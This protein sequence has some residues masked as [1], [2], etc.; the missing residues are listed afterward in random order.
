[1]LH[2]TGKTGGWRRRAAGMM[3]AHSAL[4]IIVAAAIML[5]MTTMVMYYAAKNIIH[6][7]TEMY[8]QRDLNAI[9]QSI[10]G[11]M[12]RVEEAVDNTAWV[13]ERNLTKP[14][15]MF[16]L[17]RCLLNNNDEIL[18]SSITFV[19]DYFPEK[20]FFFE[21]YAVRRSDGMIETMQLGGENH[22]YRKKEFF[23]VPTTTDRPHW[24][25]PYLDKD[26]AETSI[27]TYSVPI[28]DAHGKVVAAADADISLEWIHNVVNE[29][30]VY[31]STQ[32]FLVSRNYS[33]L[34]GHDNF[35]FHK[36]LDVVKMDSDKK[37]YVT[38]TDERGERV[39]VF[40]YPVGGM[41]DWTLITVCNDSDIFGILRNVRRLMA[42]LVLAGLLMIGI[43]VYRTSR[44]L[45][46][47]REANT[48]RERIEG[49]LR[50]A[51]RIQQSMLPPGR[52]H[53]DDMDI[54]GLQVP[55]R[56]VGGDLFDYFIRDE[57]LFF[58]IGDVSGKGTPSALLMAM[59]HALFRAMSAHES[60][61]AHIMQSVNEATCRDNGTNMFV[62]FFLGVLDLP[63]GHLRYC[64]AGHDRPIT[65]N[66]DGLHQEECVAHLPIGVFDDVKYGVQELQIPPG[67]TIFL[68]TDGLT[69]AMNEKHELYGIK[70]V[71]SLL[72]K[73]PVKEMTPE[74]LVESVV[75][76]VHSFTGNA[77]QS[78]DLTML[79]I[80]YAPKKFESILTE[81]LVMKNNIGEM[82]H[83]SNFIKSV[84]ERL[85]IAEPLAREIRL[86]V[87]EAVVNVM[88]YAY[89]NGTGGN[90]TV[91]MMSDGDLLKVKITDNGMPFDPTEKERAD[92]TLSAEERQIGGLGILLVREMMD[93]INYERKNGQNILTLTKMVHSRENSNN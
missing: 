40:F 1:M 65:I 58:C 3:R 20:G 30:K 9:A 85:K 51:S 60:N 81:R 2:S 93:S 90:V 69:E 61:P 71:V 86:A 74:R 27:T 80:H 22:D 14:D 79:V 4:A 41:T 23:M 24:C 7:R 39:H 38:M 35:I 68:Y 78:D 76:D 28:H 62:T 31:T 45:K 42:V 18:G 91:D 57:K 25:E 43:I 16:S 13:V 92:T 46:H 44:N 19:P 77:E 88:E 29:T 50:V 82:S 12:L 75:A 87:E 56:E 33:L 49:E 66:N 6:E 34:S 83:F 21:P 89:P 26:G 11:R 70:R 55:A 84:T 32:R 37:G 67:S 53:R 47:L 15:S 5:Q 73:D 64:N 10:L 36:A 52:L 17:A 59:T 72:E 8:V 54:C 63:T 48:E